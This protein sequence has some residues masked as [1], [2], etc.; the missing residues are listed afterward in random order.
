MAMIADSTGARCTNRSRVQR[1]QE[2]MWCWQVQAAVRK[3]LALGEAHL[4]A[5][6]PMAACRARLEGRERRGQGLRARHR[7]KPKL[8][9]GPPHGAPKASTTSGALRKAGGPNAAKLDPKPSTARQNKA[10]RANKMDFPGR[11]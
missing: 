2:H 10:K 5:H 6:L 1:S 7:T 4:T 8:R 11:P 9:G 3:A